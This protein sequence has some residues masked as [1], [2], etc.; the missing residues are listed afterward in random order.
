MNLLH[1]APINVGWN[2]NNF[3]QVDEAKKKYLQARREGRNVF[4]M[5]GKPLKIFNPELGNIRIDETELEDG[6]MFMRIHDKTGD[7]RITW[8]ST[9]PDQVKEAKSL[10]DKFVK[11]GWKPYAIT[12][13]GTKGFR[14]YEFDP[15]KQEI[16]ID[17]RTTEDKMKS[18]AAA[19]KGEKKE[20]RRTTTQKLASF[21][22]QFKEVKLM[23]ST[24]PG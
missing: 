2:H 16:V 22:Q 24:Y 14:I 18:F 23:P 17:D 15:V 13:S 19:V 11:K 21:V 12:R 7:R 10:Y 8:K 4:G 1:N 6:E 3:K 9:D 20:D 5:D